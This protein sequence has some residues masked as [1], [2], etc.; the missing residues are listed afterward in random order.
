M[1]VEPSRSAALKLN[2]IPKLV[3]PVTFELNDQYLL[4]DFP[5]SSVEVP[6][7]GWSQLLLEDRIEPPALVLPMKEIVAGA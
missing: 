3:K 6:K 5:P 1:F 7:F 2:K 4:T